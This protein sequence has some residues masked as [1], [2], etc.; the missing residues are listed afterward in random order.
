[1]AVGP[2]SRLRKQ[3]DNFGAFA[4]LVSS[5][6]LHN[7]ITR[8]V[9]FQFTLSQNLKHRESWCSWSWLERTRES[10]L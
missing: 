8:L 5:N 2:S 4:P 9:M 7:K 6:K 10:S 1:M 3:A